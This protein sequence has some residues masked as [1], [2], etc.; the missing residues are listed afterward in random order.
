MS[1]NAQNKY[2]GRFDPVS[3]DY[4]QGKFKN[5]SSPSSQDGSYMERDWLNDIYGFLGAILRN[6]N[7]TPNGNVDT[8]Q[9]S[10]MYDSLWLVIQKLLP[11]RSFSGNDYIRIPDIPG[12]LIIQWGTSAASLSVTTWP[13]AFPSGCLSAVALA[14]STATTITYTN[15]TT[16]GTTFAMQSSTTGQNQ[17]GALCRYIAVGF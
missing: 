3:S 10:Q 7:V 8:A 16:T 15:L 17:P 5:R 13:M 12:G 9:S 1:I 6:A 14:N 4:P 2:P 11:K